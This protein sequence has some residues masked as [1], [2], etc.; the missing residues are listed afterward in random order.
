MHDDD[1]R[2]TQAERYDM[3]ALAELLVIEADN[4]DDVHLLVSIASHYFRSRDFGKSCSYY[5]RALKV[6]PYDGW[7]HLYFGNLLSAFKLYDE[8]RT[9]FNYAAEFLSDVACPHWCLG[10]VCRKQGDL[11]R[12]EHHYRKGVEIDPADA[13]ANEK[14]DELIAEIS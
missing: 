11:D 2:A 3:L 14:L 10:D 9:H 12:A 6:D 7:S 8:A 4:S 1:E 5:V 13:K